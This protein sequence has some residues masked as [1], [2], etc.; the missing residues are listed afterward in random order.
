MA[1]TD[2]H[3]RVDE[4]VKNETERIL[5]EL[6]LTISDLVN[7]TMRRTIRERGI[8]FEAKLSIA[9]ENLPENMKVDSIEDLKRLID[10]SIEGDTGIRYSM[11]EVRGHILAR[12]KEFKRL[13]KEK[14]SLVRE[15]FAV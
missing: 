6:G 12:E 1:T 2:M 8:P 9:G 15:Q 5:K 11:D 10:E 14:A 3:V 7:I 4:D 13:R